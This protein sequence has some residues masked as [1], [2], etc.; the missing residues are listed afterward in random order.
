MFRPPQQEIQE[1][2][3]YRYYFQGTKEPLIIQACNRTQARA[4]LA[5]VSQNLGRDYVMY[6]L[7]GETVT[8]MLLGVSE[9]EKDGK[10]YVWVGYGK[11]KDGW[12]EK[13]IYEKKMK[14]FED[15]DKIPQIKSRKL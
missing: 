4:A 6:K 14:K 10:A 7:I 15:K 5:Q 3:L 2:K 8:T 9:I 1:P 13:T 11:S 12:E